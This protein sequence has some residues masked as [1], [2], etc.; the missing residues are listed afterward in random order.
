[1]SESSINALK[2][3]I[4][5]FPRVDLIHMPT[6]INKM[7]HLTKELGGPEIYIK[8]E[9][10]TGLA[11]GGNKSRKLQYII[12]DVLDKKCDAVVTW[13]SL[14][15]NWCLQTAAAARKFGITPILV[16]FKS[17]DLPDEYDGNMLLDVILDAEIKIRDAEKGRVVRP[18][19]AEDVVE[20]VMQEARENGYTPYNIPLGGSMA[21]GSMEKPIGSIGYVESFVELEGQSQYLNV[22][23]DYIIH[24]TGSG[25]TQAGLIAGACALGGRT[26][27]LGISVSEGKENFSQ[28]VLTIAQDTADALKLETVPQSSDVMVFDDY[29]QDGYGIVNKEV[30]D[31]LRFIAIKEGIF[32]DPVYTSKAMYALIDL[33]KKGFFS[34]KDKIVFYHTGGTPA[35]FP[36][37]G[38]ITSFLGDNKARA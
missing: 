8:R 13:A 12:H 15:S 18:E 19:D 7:E 38:L 4:E 34:G 33:V 22:D 35:L 28:L 1:M 32:L 5:L 16:L 21:G 25:G 2:S 31:I 26:K 27:I 30:V 11:F 10:L 20:E 23:F 36:N 29:I 6:P 14:Q 37:K 17:Y 3:K 9:D 24:A